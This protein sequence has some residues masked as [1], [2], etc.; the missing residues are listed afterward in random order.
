MS[1]RQDR[2]TRMM[3]TDL[4]K[5]LVHTVCVCEV[6]LLSL[7]PVFEAFRFPSCSRDFVLHLF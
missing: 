1:D 2:F 7:D 4:S 6:I 5:L 3:T